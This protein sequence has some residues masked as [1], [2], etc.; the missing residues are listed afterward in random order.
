MSSLPDA[1]KTS[2]AV[3]GGGAVGAT[4]ALEVARRGADVTLFEASD[5]AGGSTGRAAG[6]CY[7]AFAGTLDA[8]LAAEAME[9]FRKRDA[10]TPCPYVWLAREGDDRNA[11]AMAEHV[12]RMQAN[13]RDVE[14]IDPA[15][16]EDEWPSL[17]TDDIARAAIAHDAGY[18]EPARYTRETAQFAVAAGARLRTRTRVSV[19]S[20]LS[21]AGRA[22]D[23]VVVAA[24]AHTASL[25]EAAGIPVPVK[26]YRV[27]AFRSVETPLTNRVPML[28]DATGGY[29]LRPDGGRLLVGDGTVPEERDPDEWDRSADAW[30]REACADYLETAVGD[31]VPEQRSWAGLCTATPDGDPIVGERA[32]GIYVAAGFQ[33]HGF[34]RA[35]AVGKR[36]AKQVLGGD[37]IDAFAPDR[38]DGD[39]EFDIVEG[40]TLE[41]G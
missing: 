5:V 33:G 27:Q 15:A 6:I 2:V 30:F 31:T 20:D 9:T 8:E 14:F 26:A 13:G 4:T 24:G 39:E 25:L 1:E 16:L 23:A 12:P 37:G 41:D 21:V 34:M 7:D 17:R 29:Y 10:L 11:E 32:P 36:L 3:V 40:M 19:D 28:Y 38:F 35:P 18:A 22:Y